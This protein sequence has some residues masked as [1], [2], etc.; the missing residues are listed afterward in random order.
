MPPPIPAITPDMGASTVDVT[1]EIYKGVP[2]GLG[3]RVPMIVVS[4]WTAGGFVNS[5][6]FDHTS[7]LRFLETRFGIAAP[8]ISDWRRAVTGDL[9]SVFDFT[10]RGALK[11]FSDGVNGM[12]RADKQCKLP[13]PKYL[14]EDLPR[15]E[16]GNRPARALPYDLHVDGQVTANGF[17]IDFTN[18]GAAGAAFRI[19]A[20]DAKTGP[21]FFTVEA[22]KRLPY[23]LPRKGAY[24]FSVLGPNG[25]FRRFAGGGSDMIEIDFGHDKASGELRG[26][27]R[28]GSG[29]PVTLMLRNAY[30]SAD[31][32]RSISN[33]ESRCCQA[34]PS[35]KTQIGTMS[36][37]RRPAALCV[38]SRV[39]SR[40]ACRAQAT[41]C[42]AEES[43]AAL[44]RCYTESMLTV[45]NIITIMRIALVPV[46]AL[47]FVLPAIPRA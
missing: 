27:A 5:Q 30:A 21:W 13:P 23:T 20:S 28:N 41:R 45:P 33:P 3:P 15:Q 42:L 12:Q 6:V 16:K 8:N 39:I 18:K 9:T 25:F 32:N 43:R 4:P 17:Q 40:P 26:E 46:F 11:H 14:S 37:L 2:F 31:A 29:F 1:G 24:D 47:A 34:S 36:D 38:I 19:A 35:R 22:G 7:V 44:A 10:Q